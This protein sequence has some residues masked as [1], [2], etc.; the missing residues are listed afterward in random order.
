M[1]IEFSVTNHRSFASEQTLDLLAASGKEVHSERVATIDGPL[2]LNVLT[3]ALIMGKNGGGKSSLVDAI[4]TARSMVVS[5]ARDGQQGDALPW[6][7]FMFDTEFAAN[8]TSFRILFSVDKVIYQFAYSFNASRITQESLYIA[9]RTTRFRKMYDRTTPESGGSVYTFGDALK[10]DK[11]SWSDATRENALFLS[12][13]VQLNSASLREPFHW[14][15]TYFRV[16]D[17]SSSPKQGYTSKHCTSQVNKSSVI[18]F[19]QIF[20]INVDDIEIDEEDFDNEFVKSTFHPDF[21][22]Q[23]LEGKPNKVYRPKLVR[24]VADGTRVPIAL[25]HE[26][27]GTQAL[28]GLA[29]PIFD[30]LSKGNCLVVDEISTSLHPLALHTLVELFSDP[31]INRKRA[32]LIFT[33]HDT[34]LLRDTYFRRDQVWF[35]EKGDDRRSVLCPLSDYSPRKGEALDRGYLGGRYGG[36]PVIG[37]TASLAAQD[38]LWEEVEF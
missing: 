11:A 28:F 3:S 34:S 12:T 27:T 15:S 13:A 20:D 25:Q 19:L 7:P 26:S 14:L 5:S 21:M 2:S 17:A 24:K 1:L 30:T 36:V 6:D 23:L 32:Q 9:D 10:G 33:S 18:N 37:S 22:K 35:A 31:N 38:R 16:L 4:R 8:D 29:G